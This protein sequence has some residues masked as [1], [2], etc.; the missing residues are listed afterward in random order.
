MFMRTI[1]ELVL[2]TAHLLPTLLLLGFALN[3]YVLM[4]FWV[5][6]RRRRHRR[7][8]V[9]Q[10]EF[11]RR[12][13]S[14]D[15]PPVVTQ[16][17]VYN[18]YNVV[19]RVMRAAAAMEYPAGRH[20]I[21]VLDDSNDESCALI[22]SVAADLR[23]HGHDVQVVRRAD[24]VGFK[25]GALRYGMTQTKAD[26]FAIFDADFI[27]PHDF[28][29]K[30]MPAMLINDNTCLVQ[31]RWGHLNRNHSPI[32]HA[33]ALG[34]DG[35]FTLD[36]GARSYSGLFMNFNGTAGVWRRQAIDAAGGWHDDTLTEDLDLSYRAQ[37]A[38]WTCEYLFDL[39]VPAELPENMNALKAQ[40]FRWAKGSIQTAIK[41]LPSVFRSN[42]SMI[43]K[44]QAFFQMCGYLVHPLILWVAMLSVPYSIFVT[45][46]R[47]PTTGLLPFLF[48]LGTFAP[49]V[50]YGLPQLLIYK[51]RSWRHILYLPMITIFGAGIA[52]SNTRAVFQA[53]MGKQSAFIRTP[54][55]GDKPSKY[56]TKVSR[57]T[58]LEI[59]AGAYCIGAILYYLEV[60]KMA[61]VSY[62]AICATGFLLVAFTSLLHALSAMR[63]QLVEDRINPA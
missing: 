51:Q 57:M 30:T 54:K 44:I 5:L 13:T 27:P 31:A 62:M 38:G 11:S 21:Q 17:P 26:F 40:Q 50:I 60:D 45:H 16:I 58:L 19:E 24:R 2:F 59:L 15:L 4:I 34:L 12:F 56:K 61:A 29:L 1:L 22:D 37:L 8:E 25:A 36:Q 46:Y 32:T 52:I 20:T 10:E 3:L 47:Y 6:N 53:I 33:E 41:L 55:S 35:H 49:Y 9:I 42:F 28:L 14:A 48:L 18:E 43:A 39:V 7:I 23:H 63:Q